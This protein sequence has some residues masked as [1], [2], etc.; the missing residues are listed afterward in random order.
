MTRRVLLKLSG[1]ALGGDSG[2]GLD[3]DSFGQIAG[4][5]L[6]GSRAGVQIGIVTGGGNLCRG[7]GLQLPGL[8]R[9]DAD[10]A[11]MLATV[12]NGILLGAAIRELG[13][14]TEVFSPWPTGGS[15][16]IFSARQVRDR[17]SAGV[18]VI[19]AGGTGHP[20]FTTDTCASLRALELDCDELLKAT[21]VDGVYSADPKED[22]TATRLST[23]T[24]TEVL[25]RK[26]QVMDATAVALC[27]EYQLPIRVFSVAAPGALSSAIQGTDVG[28]VVV[29]D[30]P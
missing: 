16:S 22:R 28:T 10:T 23:V 2:I 25:E 30:A 3:A 11:G 29:P 26:L 20:F 17:L 18:I 19:L 9:T 27:R 14:S 15:T 13:A 5:V 7:G 6:E 12:M 1:E 8:T 21:Q 24:F 4:C